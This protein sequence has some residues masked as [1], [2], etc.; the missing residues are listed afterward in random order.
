M[1]FFSKIA[2]GLKKTKENISRKI[3]EA[4]KGKDLDDEFY[5]ELEVA[6]LSADIGAY[7]TDELIEELKT[8]AFKRKLRTSE[9]AKNVFVELLKDKVTFEVEPYTYPLCIL[10]AGVNGVGKTTAIGKLAYMFTKQGKSVVLAA[11]DTFRAAAGEQLEEWGERSKVRVI[12]H[13]EGADPAAVVFDAINSAKAKKT[14]VL[15]IDTAGRL[16]VKKNLMEELAKINRVVE[17]NYQEADYRTYIVL[18][19]S[20]G[21]NAVNQVEVFD[22]MIDI[23]GIILT[24]LDGTS[25]GG[26]VVAICAEKEIPV[27]YVGVG[28]GKEDLL[29]FDPD[30][31]VNAIIE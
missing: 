4:F 16:H 7:A 29:P 8:E 21:Q 28:E 19:A 13:E 25:K 22:E 1:G 6:L 24:K 26:V 20:T 2:Q 30:D 17:K 23:D 11:G 18:D 12:K 5:E 10:I 3:Y 27:L 31:F 14:D 9:E 15:L